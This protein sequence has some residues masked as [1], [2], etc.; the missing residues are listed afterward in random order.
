M[1]NWW[2]KFGCFLTGYNFEIVMNSSEVSA[3]TV[4]R[5]TSAM[6][7]VCALWA[8]IGFTF[9]QRYLKAGA[10]GSAIGSLVMCIVIIQIE[11]QI[12]LSIHRNNYLFAFRCV[13]AVMMALLGSIILDQVIFAQDIDQEKIALIDQKVNKVYPVKSAELK[14]QIKELD[15]TIDSKEQERRALISDVSANPTIK[16]VT[17]NTSSVPVSS[18]TTDTEKR[19]TT[20]IKMI[21]AS[22][23]SMSSIRNPKMDLI[24]PLDKQIA[25]LRAQK[26]Q[27]DDKLLLLRPQ[28]EAEITSKVGFLDELNI[29]V[30]ILTE[31]AAAL[32][33]YVIIFLFL[34]GLEMFILVSKWGD[35]IMTDYDETILH[36]MNFQLYKLRLLS[37]S[38]SEK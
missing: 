29:M 14:T 33:V 19:T 38:N 23:S 9:T 37:K 24:D 6:I 34:F 31:S 22:S 15:T 16:I 30:V 7:I 5:Y 2:L 13:I 10:F 11:R 26:T 32:V 35:K 36:Q 8:L 18:I 21:K 27:K 17:N 1:K 3:K 25:Y 20:Q 12:I 4:K 28:L